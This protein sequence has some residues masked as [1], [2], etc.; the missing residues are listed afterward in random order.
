MLHYFHTLQSDYH[1][2]SSY[3]L[4]PHSYLN[5]TDKVPIAVQY[6]H[7]TYFIAGHVYL[8][9]KSPPI[10]PKPPSPSP[11]GNHQIVLCIYESVSIL[12]ILFLDS[13]YKPY[14]I[15]LSLTYFTQCNA[16]QIH[17]C[18]HKWKDFTFMAKQCSTVFL[19]TT[20]SL[21][22]HQCTQVSYFR[23]LNYCK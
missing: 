3:H 10:S 20:S 14:H 17:S 7:M 5:I 2:K 6:I 15:C 8:T 21:A 4:P 11:S 9:S 16:L 13:T 12:F 19:Y 23:Y 18:C 1:D 22:I